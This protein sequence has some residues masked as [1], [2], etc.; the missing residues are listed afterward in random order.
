MALVKISEMAAAT[1]AAATDL[2]EIVQGSVN[3]KLEAR[4]LR[5]QKVTALT[6][7][8]GTTTI[9]L[10]LGSYFTATLTENTT[11][12]FSNAPG[13][14]FG[15]TVMVLITQASS[16]KTLTWPAS[17]KWEGAAPAIS[18]GSGATDLLALTTFDNGATWHATLSKG[19]A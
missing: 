17:F 3:K 4:M 7:A 13:S 11:L 10:S 14:G 2:L 8:S 6:S 12:A 1:Y 16:A 19:R 15:Q 9:D 18:T 5:G